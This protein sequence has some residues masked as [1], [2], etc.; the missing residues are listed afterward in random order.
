MLGFAEKAKPPS[1][2][3]RGGVWFAT[4][5]LDLHLGVDPDFRPAR[6]AH[7]AFQVGGLERVRGRLAAAGH[8]SVADDLLPGYRRC[9]VDDPFAN[10]IELL[11]PD[12]PTIGR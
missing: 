10:R 4:A 7:V 2:R 8:A 5:N 6:K 3:G 11:E 9:Y 12:E 1:L